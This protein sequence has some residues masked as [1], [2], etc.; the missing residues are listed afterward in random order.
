MRYWTAQ[1]APTGTK[2][3]TTTFATIA[4][5][6]GI[7]GLYSVTSFAVG[8]RTREIGIRIALDANKRALYKLVFQESAKPLVL[9][10]V[11]GC[12][13]LSR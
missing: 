11:S 1:K 12:S 10:L 13:A 9:G 8:P 4:M 6:L 2:W 3:M 5:L 7:V